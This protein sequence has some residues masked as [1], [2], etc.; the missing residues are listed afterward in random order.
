MR[1]LLDI[2]NDVY[3]TPSIWNYY[4]DDSTLSDN[5]F[6]TDKNTKDFILGFIK[7]S[8]KSK[9]NPLYDT[10]KK[11]DNNRIRHI[12]STF[13][14]G[15]YLY[16][17]I[18]KIKDP[19]D[20]VISRYKK[21]NPESTIKFPFI[22]YLICLFHDSGYLIEN[23]KKYR[24]FDDFIK[25]YK[26]KFFLKKPV[27]V[28]TLY[29][30]VYKYYFNYRINHTEDSIKKP[31]HGIC[32]S[33]ILFNTLKKILVR[34]Q[35]KELINKEPENKSWNPKL[36]NIYRFASW[37]ILSHNIFFIRKGDPAEQNYEDNHLDDLI[38]DTNSGPKID[39]IKHSF[40]FLF[41]LVDSIEPVKELDN[42]KNLNKLYLDIHDNKI[43][44]ELDDTKY[45][46]KYFKKVQ[47]L[48]TW[49]VPNITRNNNRI[50]IEI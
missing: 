22:W 40:L 8:D 46:D 34:K 26:V 37:V 10:V 2:Y 36:L 19:I 17:N 15:I 45:Q 23:K 31:D 5:P 7:L 18:Q 27:G 14:L 16:N 28:P 12:V 9:G 33:I 21:Q 48:K 30:N 13:F 4:D 3:N 29:G 32:G 44:L 39:Y 41:A 43:I 20:I 24:D 50:E 42:F 47:D 38:L 11:L 35:I 25:D 6:N 1:S 49:L